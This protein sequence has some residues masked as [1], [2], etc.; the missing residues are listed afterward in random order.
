MELQFPM[1]D[2][3]RPKIE[4]PNNKAIP[5]TGCG[6]TNGRST[7]PCSKDFRGNWYRAKTY[8][9]GV[10]K[11]IPRR[12]AIKEQ[13]KVKDREF[14]TSV[15]KSVSY[16]CGGDVLKR[17]IRIGSPMIPT[18]ITAKE[19]KVAFRK[20]ALCMVCSIRGKS[21]GQGYGCSPVSGVN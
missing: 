18:A 4:N 6:I 14:R 9:R 1:K 7:S 21:P 15:S 13:V 3:S 12:V 20:G 19:E 8:A 5:A 2:Q 17:R 10:P 11:I 16:T